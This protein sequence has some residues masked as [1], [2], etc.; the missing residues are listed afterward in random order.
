[1]KEIISNFESI[2]EEIMTKHAGEWIA[3]ADGTILAH[4]K[5]FKLLYKII[6]EKYP[7]KKPLIGK[8]P[9]KHP[10]VLSLV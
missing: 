7:D 9:E 3:V 4:E 8:I 10:M 1:M 5:S 6:K 2:S